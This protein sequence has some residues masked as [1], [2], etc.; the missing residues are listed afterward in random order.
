MPPAPSPIDRIEKRALL[1]APVS[2]VW[3][4]ISDAGE[5]G[6]WFRMRFDGPFRE[7]GTVRGQVLY[8]GY[9][10][11]TAEIQI[12]RIQPEHH[13]AYRWRPY[14][15]DPAIDYSQEPTTLV[16]FT[17]EA[18]GDDTALTVVES[19]FDHIPA[20]RRE[21]AHQRNDEGWTGQMENIR[22]HVAPD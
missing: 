6:T 11:M 12:V 17:L 7:G 8:P 18:T 15:A 2:R 13:L 3:R 20:Y 4:A 10:H 21:E 5:F 1:R 16:E 14:P 22:R 9:E 19:G